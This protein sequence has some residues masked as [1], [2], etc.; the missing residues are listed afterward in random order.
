MRAKHFALV[1]A[2]VLAAAPVLVTVSATPAAAETVL[3]RKDGWFAVLTDFA[4][5]RAEATIPPKKGVTIV[6]SRPTGRQYDPGHI[7]G[8]VSI[9]DSA[10][11]K[12][13]DKLPADK[14]AKLIF[15][16]GGVDCMLSH[17]SARKAQALGYTNI[18][19][20]AE[21][22]PDWKAKGGPVAVSAAHIKKLMDEKQPYTLIDAR[23]KRV[24]DKG[25][26]PT[27][28]AISDTDFD[29]N[30]DKLPADKAAL[31][32]YYCGG[33]ECVLS[34]A[35]AEKARKLGWTNVVTYPEGYPEWT[36]LY[37]PGPSAAAETTTPAAAPAKAALVPGK[38][39]GSV[40]VASFEAA[41]KADPAS[42]VLVDVRNPAEYA[43]GTLEGA[44]NVPMGDLEKKLSTL[45]KD[46]PIVFLCG[47]GA[48]AGEA[49]DT[50][51]MFAADLPV[52]F[53]DATV[54]FAGDG[55]ATMTQK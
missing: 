21:G 28:I 9:P 54:K 20:Y 49:Y 46:K 29:K 10:F 35:S 53:L 2:L 3:Q 42:I 17:D 4:A 26:I 27:A 5:V 12:S 19:V 41:W 45:P 6:D 23:P 55:T 39:K 8:A 38:E 7:P 1:G 40:T 48:R 15:Y 22:M 52:A 13:V 25:M 36:K 37:G 47:T 44:I 14:A 24:T 50:A 33:L 43:A 16:C 30:V 18:V 34:D 51:K 11:D 32:I 31:V